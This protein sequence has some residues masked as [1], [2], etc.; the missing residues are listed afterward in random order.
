M[1]FRGVAAEVEDL[2]RHAAERVKGD[3]QDLKRHTK[4]MANNSTTARD[5]ERLSQK[6][7]KVG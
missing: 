2:T 3:Y 6:I 4:E 5:H 7:E 1:Q